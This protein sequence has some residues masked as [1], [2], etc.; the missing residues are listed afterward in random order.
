MALPAH[1]DPAS[2]PDYVFDAARVLDQIALSDGSV[3]GLGAVPR[4]SGGVSPLVAWA[5]PDGEALA[6]WPLYGHD[7]YDD[8]EAA[9]QAAAAEMLGAVLR[10]SGAA[11]G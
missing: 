2:R 7:R 6:S 9:V 1:P 4:R 5:G 10:R 11:G 8:E 3:I